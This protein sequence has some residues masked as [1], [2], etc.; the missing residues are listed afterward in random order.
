MSALRQI[1]EQ[2]CAAERCPAMS[3][4]VLA[5][6]NDPFRV[7]TPA[8][9][10]DG[11]WLAIQA[12]RLGLLGSCP[13]RQIHLRGLHYMLVSST[14]LVKANGLPYRNTEED[15]TWLCEDAAKAARWLGYI[16]FDRII[17]ARNTEPVIR[18]REPKLDRPPRPWISV[19]LHIQIP[20]AVHLQPYVG[21]DGF[22]VDQP[23]KLVFYGEK[24]SLDEVLSPA[25]DRCAADLYLP[26]GEITDTQLYQMAAAGAEDGRPMVVFCFSDCDPAGWQMP[27]SIARKL[28]A[29]KAL[30]FPELEFQVRRVALSP[31]QVREHGLPSSPLKD[32][33]RRADRWRDRMNVEQ[34]EID[35]LAALQPALL[36]RLARE[37]V[38]PFYDP[39]LSTRCLAVSAQWRDACQRAVDQQTDQEH[40]DRLAAQ[41]NEA[42]DT[43]REQL[44]Q[45][46]EQ[47]RIHPSDYELPDPPDVPE[48]Q[49]AV[50]PDG[51][52]LIDSA[53][54]WAEQSRRLI[55]SKAYFDVMPN[56]E[57]AP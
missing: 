5:T 13:R 34:T 6:Q 42:L 14:G 32:T 40:L 38:A 18:I 51:A 47:V 49:I 17:D 24:T 35:A 54:S 19:G 52:P 28:Q 3:L 53:W 57:A 36:R 21:V 27:I 7:D 1:L 50:E 10:R 8:R 9:Y 4:T 23:C 45:L 31:D 2:A 33:E 41:A 46:N 29:F 37:A 43:V 16:P 22:C 20:E 12:E 26:A 39:T 11:E 25:A 48:P 56:G 30:L 44:R 15:W 55:A